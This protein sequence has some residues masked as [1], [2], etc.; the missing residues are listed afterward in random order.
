MH[1]IYIHQVL[2]FNQKK[3]NNQMLVNI[4]L[5]IQLIPCNVLMN[6]GNLI[7]RTKNLVISNKIRKIQINSN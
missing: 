3:C 6:K 1:K 5:E 4:H 2:H 7:L